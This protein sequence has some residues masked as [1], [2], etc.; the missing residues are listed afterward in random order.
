MPILWVGSARPYILSG[1]VKDTI[2]MGG[3]SRKRTR[4]AKQTLP[5]VVPAYPLLP[6]VRPGLSYTLT[7]DVKGIEAL[8]RLEEARRRPLA[9]PE[10]KNRTPT[11]SRK[12]LT[13]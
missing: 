10:L 13:R 4:A 3:K 2:A 8:I 9:D 12:R 1:L 5:E 6:P 7:L 11:R